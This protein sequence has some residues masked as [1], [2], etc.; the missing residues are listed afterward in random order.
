MNDRNVDKLLEQAL[1]GSSPGQ[2][3]RTKVLLDS[4]TAFVCARRSHAR[5]RFAVLSAAAVVIAAVSFL[6]GRCSV[7]SDKP[8]P[9]VAGGVETVAVP[10]DLVA[11]L[12]AAC[13]FK[14]LGMEGRAAHAVDRATQLLSRET[15][16]AD[17]QGGRVFAAG[18]SMGNQKESKE[19]TGMPGPHP[20]IERVNRVLAQSLGD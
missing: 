1:S 10:S 19:P 3:F 20:S 9:A 8:R 6:L 16:L 5:W 11:W 4:T 14:Q 18:E 7:P 17:A 15:L 12:D 13:L 2:A